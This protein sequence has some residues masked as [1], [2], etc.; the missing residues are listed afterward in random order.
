MLFRVRASAN[1]IRAS[2]FFAARLDEKG[3]AMR[4]QKVTKIQESI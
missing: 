3:P 2:F 1:D 4:T